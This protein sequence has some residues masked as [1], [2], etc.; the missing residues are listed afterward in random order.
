MHKRMI[1]LTG[2]QESF[3]KREAEKLGISLSDLIRRII[4]QYREGK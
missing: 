3:L 2:P 1:S 4:D